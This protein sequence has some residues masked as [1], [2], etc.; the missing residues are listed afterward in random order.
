MY[1]NKIEIDMI[2]LKNSIC[3]IGAGMII[4]LASC[5]NPMAFRTKVNE[6]GSLDKTIVIGKGDEKLASEN[7]FGIGER[8][9][10]AV[11]KDLLSQIDAKNKP[12]YRISFSK[13]F[14]GAPEMNKEL[15]RPNDTLFHSVASFEKKYR[16]FYT[17]IRYSETIRP[18]NRFEMVAAGDYFNAEDS[19]FIQRL[20]TEGKA[21]SKA[22]S[23]YLDMLNQKITER[24]ATMAMFKEYYRSMEGVIRKNNIGNN[25]LDTL[26]KNRNF[27]YQQVGNEDGDLKFENIVDKLKIPLPREK[28]RQDFLALSKGLNSRLAFMSFMYGG[29]Y[30]GEFEMPWAVISSNAD[31]VAAN[32]VFWKPLAYKFVFRDHEMFAESRKINAIEVIISVII[33]S[34]TVFVLWRTRSQS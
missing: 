24:F 29:K 32:R 3:V 5:D 28:A 20:P 33:V 13:H 11:R 12:E 34:L 27:I 17:Y 23:L 15:D 30:E 21:I 10:W 8:T 31:S 14:A 22:D 2:S 6:D 7:V 16:W 9:G 26:R 25:W 19:L 18:I 1:K 4:T